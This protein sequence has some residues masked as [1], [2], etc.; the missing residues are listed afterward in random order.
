MNID[1]INLGLMPSDT[2]TYIFSYLSPKELAISSLVS[3]CFNAHANQLIIW[4]PFAIKVGSEFTQED[5]VKNKVIQYCI[6]F[7]K[8]Y[9]EFFKTDQGNINPFDKYLSN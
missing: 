4:E 2:I 7:N 3:R 9:H 5:N 1:N 6:A 8:C